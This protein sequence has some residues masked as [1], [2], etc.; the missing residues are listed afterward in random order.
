MT[1]T[2]LAP[3]PGLPWSQVQQG[4]SPFFNLQ[5][6]ADPEADNSATAAR[7]RQLAEDIRHLFSWQQLAPLLPIPLVTPESVPPWPGRR[8]RSHYQWRTPHELQTQAEFQNL[9]PFDL[10]LRL[11]DFQAWRPILGQRFQG[12]MGPPAFDPVSLGLGILLARYQQWSWPQLTRELGSRRGGDYRRRLGFGDDD[13]PSA[14]TWRM[15]LART[16]VPV[17]TQCADSLVLALMAWDIIPHHSTW[18]QDPPGRGV[19]ITLDSQLVR[20]RSRQRCRFQRAECW[21]PPQPRRCAAQAAGKRGCACEEEVCTRHCRYVT[22]RDPDARYVYYAGSNQPG[23]HTPQEQEK[24]GKSRGKH[25]FGYKAKTFQ[26]IDDRLRSYWVLSGPYVPA[27]RNDHLQTL[28]GFEDLRQRFPFLRIGEVLADAGE[29]LPDIL[30]YV[31]H[32]LQAL[33]MIDLRQHEQDQNPYTCLSRGYDEQGVPLCACGYRLSRHGHDYQR[34]ASKWVCRQR[35]RRHPQPDV[36]MAEWPHNPQTC[37]YRH[38]DKPLGFNLRVGATLPD[39]SLRLARE[40]RVGSRTWKARMGRRNYAESRNACQ[41]RR[42]LH[43]SPWF[44]LANSAKAD[45]L[46]DIL[47]N[48]LNLARFVTEATLAP[49]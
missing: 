43:R 25:H 19:S 12:S 14:S 24:Q 18:P 7:C 6:L 11:F 35:C 46:G 36:T 17:W 27:N 20:S 10:L 1:T 48:A 38:E 49:T 22:A 33:R 4:H 28:P 31:Y 23:P 9:D 2:W 34:R 40:F 45:L 41:T 16:P 39:G 21:L 8:C 15:A 3:A 37:P 32:D 30:S 5:G 29:G 44:G 26:V 42:G 47:S 13:I